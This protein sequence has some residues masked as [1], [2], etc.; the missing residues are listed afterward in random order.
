MIG[1]DGEGYGVY[2]WWQEAATPAHKVLGQ[3][4]LSVEAEVES[5]AP[6]SAGKAPA[7]ASTPGAWSVGVGAVVVARH[8][9]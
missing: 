2:G 6:F 3:S 7:A 5:S 9:F 4:H 1:V 8:H